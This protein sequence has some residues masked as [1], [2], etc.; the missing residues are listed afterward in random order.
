M[1]V[2]GVPKVEEIIGQIL[3]KINE[4][5]L[6]YHNHAGNEGYSII[7]QQAFIHVMEKK[8]WNIY[9]DKLSGKEQKMLRQFLL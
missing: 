5:K 8:V 1:S 3:D 2:K 7:S 6:F 9:W 4:N